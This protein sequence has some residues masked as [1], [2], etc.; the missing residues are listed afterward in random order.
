MLDLFFSRVVWEEG[1]MT[2]ILVNFYICTYYIYTIYES[3]QDVIWD[4]RIKHYLCTIE[5]KKIRS[6]LQDQVVES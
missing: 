2:K 4:I 6:Y 3:N 1:K 5:K